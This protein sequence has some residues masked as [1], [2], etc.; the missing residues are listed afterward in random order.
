MPS[1]TPIDRVVKEI[2]NKLGE[3]ARRGMQSRTI[4]NTFW[5]G[6]SSAT[7][8]IIGA[9]IAGILARYL[10][11]ADYG[12]YILIVSLMAMLTDLADLGVSSSI[13]R[14]GSQS[15]AE[16]N[17]RKLETVVAIVFR[18]KL[19]VGGVVLLGALVF[20]NTI[21]DAVFSHVDKNV[22]LYFRLSLI[23]CAVGIV[24]GVFTPIYQSFKQFRLY[25]LLVS[26]RSVTKLVMVLL[27][28]FVLATYSVLMLVWI[29][30]AALVLFLIVMYGFSPLK[31]FPFWQTDRSLQREMI[32][33]TRWISLYQGITLIGGKLDVVF[34]GGLSD[35]HALGIYGAASKV[36][37]L[38]NLVAGSYMSV[39]L[40][41]ISSSLSLDV[42]KRKQRNAFVVVGL[43]VGGI[44]LT[45]LIARPIVN[46]LFGPGF[47]EA[48]TVLQILCIGLIFTVLA[49]PF[50]ATLFALNKSQVFPIMSAISVLVTIAGNA[51]LVP[52][53][54]AHG[55]AASFSLGMFVALIISVAYYLNTRAQ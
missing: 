13:V 37:G 35:A 15:I 32:S 46:L 19:L 38:M 8:G 34:V 10:G 55:A 12:V 41:E 11:V 7:N 25:S 54:A 16:G 18:W 43:I 44:A 33:F 50:N 4:G 39:L 23:G 26:S 31:K 49:Y 6:S 29:E 52:L 30:I 14:F 51:Y 40:S 2:L 21:V 45:S 5:L 22:E 9:I 47:S 1:T 3:L 53:F 24:A 28:V 36:F 20:L 27:A 17:Q 42:I 48:A